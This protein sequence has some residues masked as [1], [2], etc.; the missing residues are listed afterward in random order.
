MNLIFSY[1]GIGLNQ[2]YKGEAAVQGKLAELFA[3]ALPQG[4]VEASVMRHG[5]PQSR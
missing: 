5:G 3:E 4:G 1:V 2:Q